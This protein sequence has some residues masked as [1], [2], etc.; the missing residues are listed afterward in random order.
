MSVNPEYQIF[1]VDLST[2][3]TMTID[4]QYNVLRMVWA[5]TQDAAGRP[6][7]MN[8]ATLVEVAFGNKE[9]DFVPLGI[10]GAAFGE[11]T[12]YQ[13]RWAAQSG[14]WA[15]F[16]LTRS[17]SRNSG[18]QIEAP[19][20]RQIVTSSVGT[21]VTATAVA[22]DTTAGGVQIAAASSTRQSIVIQNLGA[23]D[24]YVGGQG[25]TSASGLQVPK[26]GGS[27]VIDK[28]TAAIYAIAASGS[29]D[30]RVLVEA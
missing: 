11:V 10:N 9:D 7:T 13:L 25:V 6:S 8:L 21:T 5:G 14:T 17:D 2:A 26:Q 18:I 23:V 3:G 29:A 19:P 28:T 4:G 30:V 12:R 16:L 27:L 20:A 22:V 15:H 24:V 1:R